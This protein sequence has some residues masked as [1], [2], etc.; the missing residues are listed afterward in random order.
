MSIKT[1]FNFVWPIITLLILSC[2]LFLPEFQGKTLERGDD[3]QAN[4]KVQ[5]MRHY[6]NNGTPSYIWNP[7]QFSGMPM[8][9]GAPSRKNLLFYVDKV[10][11]FGTERPVSIFFL[12]FLFSFLLGRYAFRFD[13]L[14]SL[15]LSILTILPLTNFILW[16]AG[17]TSKIDVL[18]YTPLIIMGVVFLFELK[19]YLL[20]SLIFT[21]GMSMSLFLRHP[22]MTYYIFLVFLIYG[23]ILIV[24]FIRDQSLLRHFLICAGLLV[25]GSILSIGISSTK[26]WSMK[27]HSEQSMR[28]APILSDV[29]LGGANSSSKT[30][31]LNWEYAM[32]WSND[33]TDVVATVIPGFNGGGSGESVSIKSETYKTYRLERAPLYWGGLPFTEAPMYLGIVTFFLFLFSAGY[34]KGHF[35]WWLVAGVVFTYMLSL[36]ANL[37]WFNRFIFDYFPYFNKFRTPNSVLS[38]TPYFMSALAVMGVHKLVH[39]GV[40]D[41]F[42]R[43]LFVAA[44]VLGGLCLLSIMAFPSMLSFESQTDQRY[45]QQGVDISVFIS[46]RMSLMRADGWRSLILVVLAAACLYIFSNKKLNATV[47]VAGFLILGLV[48]F[49]GVNNR[50]LS[51]DDYVAERV[52]QSNYEPRTVDQQILNNEPNRHTYRVH[53]LSI[54]TFNSASTSY[55]HN[56]IGGYDPVKLQRYQD[57]I[58]GYIS[59]NHMPVLNMLNAKYFIVPQGDQGPTVQFNSGALGN[60]WFV[61]NL[62]GVSTPDEEF[63]SL[64][65][66]DPKS[67]AVVSV[68]DYPELIDRV[69][70]TFSS[71]GQIEITD[72]SPDHI[73]YQSNNSQNGF[74]VFSEIWFNGKSWE[75]TIDGAVAPIYRVN[76]LLRGLELPAGQHTIE[77]KFRPPS[78]YTGEKITLASS[79]LFLLLMIGMMVYQFRKNPI[80]WQASEA[81]V[82]AKK[83][84][85]KKVKTKKKRKK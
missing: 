24:R 42:K 55:F 70:Q 22:Q 60:A 15:L 35:K 71:A 14:T 37:S 9:Y 3:I 7:G 36:G 52:I 5:G 31:G 56:T 38:T 6:Q 67:T 1:L 81:P 73:T 25:I 18:V 74:A 50:Y 43:S 23:L 64:E 33:W 17:H 40:T 82:S 29:D 57:V 77:F 2:L 63:T 53:D 19:K 79:A 75:V 41:Q 13:N 83:D 54:N 80:Q 84:L 78:F 8:L 26:I 12:G 61:D 62:K 65:T 34:V 30:E 11:R 10:I 85:N 16:K 49:I 51:F 45:V 68:N 48:D 32:A 69:G 59:K 28:G 72:Y 66:F 27:T 39:E 44:G 4:A 46:D 76:Y 58:D 21:Y 47:M 20:G